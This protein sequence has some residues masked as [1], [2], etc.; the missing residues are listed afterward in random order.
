MSAKLTSRR[1]CGPALGLI[2]IAGCGSGTDVELAKVDPAATTAPPAASKP[3]PKSRIPKKAV[4]SP[5]VLPGQG[6]N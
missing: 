2:L 3:A 1:C 4:Q 6:Q 5:A